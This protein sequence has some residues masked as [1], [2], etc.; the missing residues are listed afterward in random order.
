MPV[1]CFCQKDISLKEKPGFRDACPH[2][3]RDLHCCYQCYFYDRSAHHECREPMAE[4]V[5]DKD[6]NNFC[7]YFVFDPQIQVQPENKNAVKA[8]LEALFKKK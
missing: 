4:F 7:D 6:K 8:K 5:A 3:G 1:C 2:C